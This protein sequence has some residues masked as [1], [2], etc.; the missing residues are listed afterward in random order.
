MIYFNLK[1]LQPIAF[2]RKLQLP[3]GM[4]VHHYWNL[5]LGRKHLLLRPGCQE[6]SLSWRNRLNG[7]REI[8]RQ[9]DR[10]P[11]ICPFSVIPRFAIF[12]LDWILMSLFFIKL[13][14]SGN[15][16]IKKHELFCILKKWII[17]MYSGKRGEAGG[18]K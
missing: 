7:E 17:L 16:I 4:K 18:G 3:L 8:I 12:P 6:L 14:I 1:L 5:S 2:A 9:G 15:W 11:H 10:R 13:K